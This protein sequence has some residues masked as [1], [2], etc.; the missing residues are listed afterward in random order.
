MKFGTGFALSAQADPIALR[1]MAQ[2]LDG[3]GF[4]Y[5]TTAGAPALRTAGRHGRP[6]TAADHRGAP[7]VGGRGVLATP[8]TL[9][10]AT[11]SR[12]S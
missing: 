9:N 11:Y 2:T 12:L 7:G 5:V 4:D 8:E 10:G 1:D 3:E 6:V